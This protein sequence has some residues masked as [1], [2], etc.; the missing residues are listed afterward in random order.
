MQIEKAKAVS[1]FCTMVYTV[2]VGKK[3]KKVA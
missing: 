3:K 1:S 2:D